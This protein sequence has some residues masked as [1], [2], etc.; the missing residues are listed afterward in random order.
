MPIY[1]FYCD[2]CHTIYSFFSHTVN[3][4]KQPHC[5]K[6]GKQRLK[7]EVSLFAATGGAKE[8]DG[9]GDL[10]FDPAKM[11][12]AMEGLAREAEGMDEEDPRQAAT[13][14]RKLTNMTGMELGDG[15]QEALT[16]MEAGEDPDAIEQ[17]LGDRIEAEDPFVLPGR[18]RGSAARRRRAPAR[19]ATLY[20]L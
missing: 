5:P 19:D 2:A 20:D 12:G 8:D 1:E 16:R 4:T 18:K 11:E 9:A 6:C 3:T 15:M 17:E 10:P 14:M 7:R 13:L